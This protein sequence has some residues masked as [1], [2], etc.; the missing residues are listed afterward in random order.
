MADEQEIAASL[1]ARERRDEISRQIHGLL[2]AWQTNNYPADQDLIHKWDALWADHHTAT[3]RYEE[4]NGLVSPELADLRWRDYRAFFTA[5]A[6][7]DP[8][9]PLTESERA[10]LDRLEA[11]QQVKLDDLRTS[12]E[13][14]K[15]DPP[16]PI[17]R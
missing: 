14:L 11:A 4:L 12:M 10:T 6:P 13:K 9:V 16:E 17:E 5:L 15:P 7:V 8:A 3:L 1:V 2:T